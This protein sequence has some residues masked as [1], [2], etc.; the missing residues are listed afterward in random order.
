[1]TYYVSYFHLSVEAF[2]PWCSPQ[3]FVSMFFLAVCS[4]VIGF[5]S[6]ELLFGLGHY[7]WQDSIYILPIHFSFID[8]EFISP[9]V[10]NIPVFFSLS[11]MYIAFFLFY[12]IDYLLLYGNRGW[13]Y[14][15]L[16]NMYFVLGSWAFYAGF[17]NTIYN[18]IFLNSFSFSYKHI[19][20]FLDKGFFELF[21]PFGIYKS[22]RNLHF[23]LKYSF[24]SLIYFSISMMFLGLVVFIWYWLVIFLSIYIVLI[25]NLGLFII[26]LI[27]WYNI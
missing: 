4:V 19:N 23:S 9:F 5:I 1:M 8:I 25:K 3:M 6:S 18:R 20:K 10:K 21:G 12:Y 7:F 27:L 14:L 24:Y 16:Y 22:F 11:A 13:F 26:F 15:F 17:F 2:W